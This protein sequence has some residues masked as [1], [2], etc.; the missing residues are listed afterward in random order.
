MIHPLAYIIQDNVN[1]V[2]LCF[3]HLIKFNSVLDMELSYI[4]KFFITLRYITY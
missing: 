4:D 1:R 2:N 3:S